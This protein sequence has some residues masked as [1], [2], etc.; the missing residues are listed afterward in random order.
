MS[1]SVCMVFLAFSMLAKHE[2]SLLSRWKLVKMLSGARDF[3]TCGSRAGR[4]GH[5]SLDS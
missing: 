5:L 1:G 4:K 2:Y 3:H